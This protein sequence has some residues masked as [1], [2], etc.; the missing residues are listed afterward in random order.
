MAAEQHDIGWLDWETEPTF[1]PGTGRPHLFREVGAAA[2]APMW[3]KGVQRA[4]DAWGTHVALLASRHGGVQA[5]FKKMLEQLDVTIVVSASAGP[6]PVATEAT[7][8]LYASPKPSKPVR[9][10]AGKD[11]PTAPKPVQPRR[12]PSQ[13]PAAKAPR[14][15][16]SI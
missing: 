8:P 6:M 3:T 15:T 11:P 9:R 13:D 16:S 4:C 14:R 2:H 12:K 1:N 7:K 10:C 5:G